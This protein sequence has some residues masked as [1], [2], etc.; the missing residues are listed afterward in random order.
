[1]E[2]TPLIIIWTVIAGLVH[3]LTAS[4]IGVVYIFGRLLYVIGY[5]IYPTARLPGWYIAFFSGLALMGYA[6]SASI[7]MI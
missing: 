1:V 7:V 6:I 3:P 2:S 5:L 4:V